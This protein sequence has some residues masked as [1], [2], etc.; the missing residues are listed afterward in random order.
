LPSLAV[1]RGGSLVTAALPAARAALDE[2]RLVGTDAS[3]LSTL[4]GARA[5]TVSATLRTKKHKIE[6]QPLETRGA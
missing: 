6:L 1:P 3:D 2:H 5:G 4:V